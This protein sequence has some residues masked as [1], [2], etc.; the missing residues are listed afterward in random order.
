MLYHF[1]MA[2]EKY[3]L[4]KIAS[5]VMR[6]RGLDPDFSNAEMQQLN[7]IQAP[8]KPFSGMEDLRKLIWCSIDNDD[9]KDLDQLTYAEKS[10]DGNTIIYVA[11]ADVD[12]LV[13]K[14]TPIDQHAA[15]N[16]TSVYTPAKI[17]SMLPEKLSTGLTSLNENEDRISVVVKIVID[18]DGE[19][20]ESSIFQAQVR[21]YAQL[22]YNSVGDWLEEK[23][24]IPDKVAKL[25]ALEKNL[26]LQSDIAQL[27]KRNRDKKG[28]LTLESS[29]PEAKVI[30]DKVRITH[31]KHNFAHQ[32]IEH[33]MISANVATANFFKNHKIPSL[34]RVVKVPKN[35]DRIVQLAKELGENL[36]KQ[37]DSL[38]LDV[39][40]K[41]RK[42]KDPLT[43]PD[44]SLAIIKLLG[45]G[46][47]IVE[48][49]G[50]Q[51][52]G[53]FG[54]ALSVYTHSTA[55]NR[56]YPDI[57]SQRQIKTILQKKTDPYT[58]AELEELSTH[59]TMQ[60]DNANKVERRMI[61]SAAALLL[62]TQIGHVFPGIITGSSDRG[63][64]VRIFQPPIE[65]KVVRGFE[66][67]DV[68]DKVN[69][70]L[71]SVDVP[72]GY[73]DFIIN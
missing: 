5:Q 9:S 1:D 36:P 25:P 51:P 66:N 34:R 29:E 48:I 54:L 65:G 16:T 27:L 67:K 43:F 8:A 18:R 6:T 38:A 73:I 45:R 26:L 24:P 59:C 40:L 53:H 64:W 57:I 60:E 23:G 11:I 10:G 68:G 58:T 35:W 47:Y 44:L 20:G 39:F 21:N 2:H 14:N 28:S 7:T 41:N 19:L 46:E 31:Q 70:K 62:I 49:P 61:K 15:E 17:F 3:D 33:F 30:D 42:E 12:A 56:R 50:D 22:A 63:V 32:L 52:V 13:A 37:P 55:P 4:A 72:N 69:A 71:I